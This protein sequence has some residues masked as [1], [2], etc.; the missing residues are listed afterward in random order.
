MVSHVSLEASEKSSIALNH[1]IIIYISIAVCDC[2][3]VDLRSMDV[4]FATRWKSVK[5]YLENRAGIPL[6]MKHGRKKVL[7]IVI[8]QCNKLANPLVVKVE[9]TQ[10]ETSVME[11]FMD[12]ATYLSNNEGLGM[13]LIFVTSDGK[14][15]PII[16]GKNV[17]QLQNAFGNQ[18]M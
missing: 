11:L 13:R 10:T 16:S 14:A 17:T 8:D 7:R 4:K 2:V 9:E 5:K 6:H 15:L 1:L 3:S 12:W 18:V